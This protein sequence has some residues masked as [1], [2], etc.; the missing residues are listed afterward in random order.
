VQHQRSIKTAC[1]FSAHSQHQYF[2]GKKI[3][4]F[5]LTLHLPFV[6]Q[7]I[8][9]SLRNKKKSHNVGANI[10]IEFKRFVSTKT[11]LSQSFIKVKLSHF[12]SPCS[13]LPYIN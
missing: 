5:S 3:I 6:A 7:H 1:A 4:F 12:F 9:S 2:S 13:M 11:S 10:E 8:T